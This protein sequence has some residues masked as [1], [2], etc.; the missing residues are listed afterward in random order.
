MRAVTWLSLLSAGTVL[1]ACGGYTNL[2]NGPEGSGGEDDGSGG[3]SMQSGGQAGKGSGKGGNSTGSAGTHTMGTGGSGMGTAGTQSMGT[4]GSN[5]MGGTPATS[6]ANLP[7]GSTCMLY[8]WPEPMTDAAAGADGAADI[9]AA[10]G[11]CAPDGSCGPAFPMC[12]ST[13][14][15]SNMDC[16]PL[17]A[18]CGRCADGTLS[19]PT[20]VCVDG[21]C[22]VDAPGCGDECAT[23]MDCDVA[24][25]PCQ[26]CPDGT[27]S[28]PT[29]ECV[30]GRCVG[31]VP[32]CSNHEPCDGLACGDRCNPC[33][34]DDMECPV[35]QVLSFCNAE[36]I[37]QTGTPNC[38]SGSMCMAAQDCPQI[39]L[40]YMCADGT[41]GAV[42][43]VNGRCGFTCAEAPICMTA[44][45]CGTP[46]PICEPCADGTCEQMACVNGACQMICSA[47]M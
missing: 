38:G 37:C 15:D 5:S 7:C 46:P 44:D 8:P 43:C 3:S 23:S 33:A 31:S 42:D 30:M 9:A 29:V 45:D 25:A 27:N 11:Y 32:G 10:V 40:C 18:T 26:P 36:G 21:V 14:C 16:P 39:E 47:G 20:N 13:S 4:G 28:C 34:P 41:C 19:C 1:A 12:P 35:S 6:C 24:V 17:P 2:G 22:V